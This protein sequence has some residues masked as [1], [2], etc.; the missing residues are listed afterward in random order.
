MQLL[1]KLLPLVPMLMLPSC[2]NKQ[3]INL[4]PT[5]QAT[6]AIKAVPCSALAAVA[7][8]HADSD[9]TK[10]AVIAQNKVIDAVCGG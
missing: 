5:P 7:L 10:A 2:A 4:M 1:L 6:G 8:S 3:P 9:G